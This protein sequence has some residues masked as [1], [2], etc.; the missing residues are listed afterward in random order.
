MLRSRFLALLVLITLL[1]V[2]WAPAAPRQDECTFTLG[3][4]TLHDLIPD[5]VGDCVGEEWHDPTSGDALQYTTKGLLVWRK[6][7]NWTAFTNGFYTWVNGPCGLQ[8]RLSERRFPWESGG[9]CEG[10]VT[11]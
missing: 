3:F 4:A 10:P 1:G 9:G 8:S 6:A 7:D 2:A 11:G 5:V